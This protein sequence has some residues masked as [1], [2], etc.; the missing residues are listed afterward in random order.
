[1]PQSL[2]RARNAAYRLLAYRDRSIFEIR[3]ALKK[4]GFLN[5]EI[6]NVI[7]KLTVDGY[8]D[9]SK[10]ALNYGG[11]LLR[12]KKAGP[13][14]VEHRLYVKGV[15]KELARKTVE[16][17]FCD[18]DIQ[19]REI[20]GWIE[21]KKKSFKKGLTP[22]QKKKRIYDFLV[23]RGFSFDLIMQSLKAVSQ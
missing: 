22:M 1:M 6:E 11:S 19:K 10:F 12:N 15:E 18:P 17:L 3:T 8:L 21:K 20:M 4:K 14:Y 16:G 13:R 2:A 23:R 7:E 5:K 9:D